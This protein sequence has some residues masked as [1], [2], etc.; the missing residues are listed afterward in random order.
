VLIDLVNENAPLLFKD[1]YETPYARIH[2]GDHYELINMKSDKF[3]RYI[4]NLYYD[5]EGRAT[6]VETINSAVFVLRAQAEYR[7]QTAR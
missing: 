4:S 6:N 7:G 3:K 5:A 2:N 1:E